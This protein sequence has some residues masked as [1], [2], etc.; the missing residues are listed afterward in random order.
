[1]PTYP[2]QYDVPA[3]GYPFVHEGVKPE[4][5]DGLFPDSYFS[6]PTKEEQFLLTGLVPGTEITFHAVCLM[7]TTPWPGS[8]TPADFHALSNVVLWD[9]PDHYN[10]YYEWANP[11]GPSN[12]NPETE[13]TFTW[14]VPEGVTE[15]RLSVCTTDLNFPNFRYRLTISG[16]SSSGCRYRG[17]II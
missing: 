14:V 8:P 11:Y 2:E 16:P 12:P 13:H 6:S 4:S 7:E 17:E 3:P 15:A 1:M 5:G 10:A 9:D